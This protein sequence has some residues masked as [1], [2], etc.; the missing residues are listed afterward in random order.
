MKLF[1][2][3]TDTLSSKTVRQALA[4]NATGVYLFT[5]NA[6]PSK[7]KID[8]KFEIVFEIVL[9]GDREMIFQN[10][11]TARRIV[12]RIRVVGSTITIHW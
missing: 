1:S 6:Y 4:A 9:Q 10:D 8:G 5:G 12:I 7:P 11:G 3:L 2:F